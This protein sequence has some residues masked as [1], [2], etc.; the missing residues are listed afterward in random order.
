MDLGE[1]ESLE[2]Q[3]RAASERER[4]LWERVKTRAPGEDP[5]ADLLWAEWLQAAEQVR[6]L[7]ALMRQ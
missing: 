1:Q 2:E 4:D 3:M 7:A 5:K 6:R